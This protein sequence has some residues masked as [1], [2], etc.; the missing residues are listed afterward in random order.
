VPLFGRRR[1][2]AQELQHLLAET[3]GA[4][5][6]VRLAS[7]AVSQE[8]D[9]LRREVADTRTVLDKLAASVSKA[10]DATL[11]SGFKV[12]RLWAYV[13]ACCAL[14]AA[15]ASIGTKAFANPPA[16][17]P[18]TALTLGYVGMGILTTSARDDEVIS[19]RSTLTMTYFSYSDPPDMEYIW[20][21]PAALAGKPFVVV[22]AGSARLWNVESPS[23]GANVRSDS[24]LPR[25]LDHDCQIVS[26]NLPA[27][28][29]PGQTALVEE[30][31]DCLDLS[32]QTKAV[33]GK[34]L[35]F[36]LAGAP[37]GHPKQ[38]DLF[39]SEVEFPAMWDGSGSDVMGISNEGGDY[40]IP[41]S[42]QCRN[43]DI[44][45]E[46]ELTSATDDPSPVTSQWA[47]WGNEVGSF[48]ESVVFKRKDAERWGNL[49]VASAG[50]A[51][52]LGIGFIPLAYEAGGAWRRRRRLVRLQKR[53]SG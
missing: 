9:D 46:D 50:A 16:L 22:L 23:T 24:C 1:Q 11:A 14:A 51:F 45:D 43:T 8:I 25:H 44:P 48:G 52:G 36:V 3:K 12:L 18:F 19:E 17:N 40:K 32:Q 41:K 13:L 6:E 27:Q 28:Y 7:R 15:T 30:D 33:P 42:T 21:L 2:L 31:Q 37:I 49:C 47:V 4:A 53:A 39:H 35:Y 5:D 26:G 29:S 20:R 34:F 10:E 38:L